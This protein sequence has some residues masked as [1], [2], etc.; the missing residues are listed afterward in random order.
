[1]PGRLDCTYETGYKRMQLGDQLA[2]DE[3]A[4]LYI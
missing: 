4:K 2:S 1:M 3:N